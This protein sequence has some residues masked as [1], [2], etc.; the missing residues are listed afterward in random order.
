MSTLRTGTRCLRCD[1]IFFDKSNYN[2]HHTTYHQS[3]GPQQ[4]ES[5][6]AFKEEGGTVTTDFDWKFSSL[7]AA[8]LSA[9]TAAAPGTLERQTRRKP[10]LKT[11]TQT[12]VDRIPRSLIAGGDRAVE[13][14]REGAHG[15]EDRSANQ[16]SVGVLDTD[17][18]IHFTGGLEV[19][20][21]RNHTGHPRRINRIQPVA[22]RE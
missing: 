10:L 17:Q 9:E 1:K 20:A 7:S 5:N 18:I 8:S 3:E 16:A 13:P 21:G 19:H 14:L 11:D 2:R 15:I 12:M 22:A 4:F 6:V